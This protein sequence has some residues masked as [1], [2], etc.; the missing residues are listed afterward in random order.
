MNFSSLLKLREYARTLWILMASYSVF[1]RPEWAGRAI[2][3]RICIPAAYGS[4]TETL[5]TDHTA[6]GR[7]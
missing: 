2:E 5:P 7:E 4:I 3:Q 6:L 1:L